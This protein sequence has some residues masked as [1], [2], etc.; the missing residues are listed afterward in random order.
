MCVGVVQAG[1]RLEMEVAR[2]R[3]A[4]AVARFAPLVMAAVRVATLVL[5]AL[6]EQVA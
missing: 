6:L 4:E 2:F 3:E 1:L 5:A